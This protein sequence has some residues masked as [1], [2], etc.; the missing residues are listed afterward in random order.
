[1]VRV[2]LEERTVRGRKVWKV[3]C[4]D[5]GHVSWT[6]CYR[7]NYHEC[8][9]CRLNRE[10]T[11]YRRDHTGEVVNG[12]SIEKFVGRGGP[13]RRP[14]WKARCTKCQG[15]LAKTYSALSKTACPCTKPPNTS[16]IGEIYGTR[17]IIG[18]PVKA[19]WKVICDECFAVTWQTVTYLKKGHSCNCQPQKRKPLLYGKKSV[20]SS[21]Y[22]PPTKGS[23]NG[24]LD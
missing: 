14:L 22:Q 21:S 2:K 3:Q 15:N 9:E 4:S 11:S 6:G 12:W 16:R 7:M 20:A 17:R 8:N 13:E 1:M 10:H 19:H 23:V 18:S 5:C 24:K